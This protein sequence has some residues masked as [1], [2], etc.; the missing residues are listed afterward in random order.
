[1]P[2]P[3]LHFPSVLQFLALPLPT[4]YWTGTVLSSK[5][6]HTRSLI[7]STTKIMTAVIVLE[8]AD[9]GDLITV[10]KEAV[11]IEGSSMY[12]TEGETLSISDLLY[13]LMLHSGNDAAVALAIACS[14]SVSNFVDLMNQKAVDL[15]LMNTH[16]E[17]PNGLD[18]SNHFST[19]YDLALLTAYAL[20]IP[21]FR[22][23]VSCKEIQIGSRYFRNHNRLLWMADGIIGV[24]TGYT[25]AAGR[26]LVSAM[27]YQGRTLIAVTIN[28][29]NDWQDH[30]SLYEYGKSCYAYK[31]LV[32]KG[33]LLGQLPL[34]DGS[35][36][37]LIS[38]EDLFAW[39][40]EGETPTFQIKYP[41]ISMSDHGITILYVYVGDLLIKRLTVT[42][43][44]GINYGTNSKNHILPRSLLPTN[45]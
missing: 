9:L 34:L 2:P 11:G 35:H 24:K 10:P 12:L 36:C 21:G 15:S 4:S 20:K 31:C 44:E 37:N 16:F 17:N 23:V 39:I 27:E 7:A 43:E 32:P 40:M 38:Q 3:F 5:N 1:M 42:R 19:A 29:G 22:E 6:M 41:M 33:T 26:L 8:N 13:G 45:C 14:G 25:K 30:L 18:G 28:D